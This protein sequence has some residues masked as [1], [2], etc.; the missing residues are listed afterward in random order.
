MLCEQQEAY[1]ERA[2]HLDAESFPIERSHS[3]HLC[4]VY[5]TSLFRLGQTVRVRTRI[6][7]SFKR[8]NGSIGRSQKQALIK[9][10][11]F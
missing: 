4:I 2:L 10:S 6:I 1:L 3:V 7:G 8:S 5:E 9:M 11:L